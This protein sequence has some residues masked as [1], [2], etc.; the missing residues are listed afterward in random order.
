DD[1]VAIY[2]PPG[3]LLYGAG[4]VFCRALSPG[5]GRKAGGLPVGQNCPPASAQIFDWLSE[6]QDVLASQKIL[7]MVLLR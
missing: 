7:L 3:R 6:T 4:L 5:C 2:L 1:G